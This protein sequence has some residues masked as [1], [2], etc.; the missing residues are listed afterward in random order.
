MVAILPT[1]MSETFKTAERAPSMI[2]RTFDQEG[3]ER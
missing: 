3:V 1:G 2:A